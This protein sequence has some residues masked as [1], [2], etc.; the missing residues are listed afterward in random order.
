MTN[1]SNKKQNTN[2]LATEEEIISPDEYLKS[3]EKNE[4]INPSIKL[5]I[6]TV[7]ALWTMFAL[8]M[9]LP[10]E[11]TIIIIIA[12]VVVFLG[13]TACFLK[14]FPDKKADIYKNMSTK[15]ANSLINHI[16]KLN[17]D[18]TLRFHPKSDQMKKDLAQ[19]IQRNIKRD[20]RNIK[21]DHVSSSNFKSVGNPKSKGKDSKTDTLASPQNETTNNENNI[22]KR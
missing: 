2:L 8:A 20:Q 22:L 7:G 18:G 17:I 12:Q 19:V 11:A 14:Y 3:F 21:R 5:I 10:R 9:D 6:P 16:N 4:Y 1:R 15:Q 13:L